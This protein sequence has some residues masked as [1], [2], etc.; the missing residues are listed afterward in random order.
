M[1]PR[2][3]IA[4]LS[5]YTEGITPLEFREPMGAW[6]YGCDRCQQVCPRNEAYSNQELP[7]SRPLEERS[8]DF[9]LEKLLTM[10]D[11]HYLSRIWPLCFYISQENKAKWQMNAARAMGN[12]KDPQ[13]VQLLAESLS[14]NPSEIVRGMCAWALGR[15]G[16][17]QAK[18][19]LE[20]RWERESGLVKSEIE[21]ALSLQD[22]PL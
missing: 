5:F 19:A 12:L 16:G 2:R 20:S 8:A 7:V 6:V 14:G 17:R 15:I 13:F 21:Q 1:D 18:Q 3:C 4:F 9:C 22:S 10:T 11:E